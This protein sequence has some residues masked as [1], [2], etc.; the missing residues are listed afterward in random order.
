MNYQIEDKTGVLNCTIPTFYGH[1]LHHIEWGKTY[2]DWD[3]VQ[4]EFQHCANV[5]R[6]KLWRMN[7][8]PIIEP[9]EN[10]CGVLQSGRKDRNLIA[11]WES[12]FNYQLWD[13]AVTYCVAASENGGN[14]EYS[15]FAIDLFDT[16]WRFRRDLERAKYR[17]Q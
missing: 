12:I 14:E 4:F 6:E 10:Y 16:I 13:A 15:F 9:D 8:E 11:E 3:K 7:I 5:L 1:I 17:S 2:L